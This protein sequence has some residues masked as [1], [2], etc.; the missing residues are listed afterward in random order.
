MTFRDLLENKQQILTIDMSD[1]NGPDEVYDL[2][3]SNGVIDFE[4]DF[5]PHSDILILTF[6]NPKDLAK[7]KKILKNK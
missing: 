7:A 3:E 2:L 5:Q 6:K 1:F 4:S